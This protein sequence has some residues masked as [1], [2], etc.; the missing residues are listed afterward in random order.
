MEKKWMNNKVYFGGGFYKYK[1]SEENCIYSR[2][3][4]QPNDP[5]YNSSIYSKYCNY[6]YIFNKK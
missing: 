5:E 6:H 4:H 1:C 3:L 2:K